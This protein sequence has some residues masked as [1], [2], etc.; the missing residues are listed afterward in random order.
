MAVTKLVQQSPLQ[1][2]AQI[3]VPNTF[4]I[5]TSGFGT[6]CLRERSLATYTCT[7]DSP[8]MMVAYVSLHAYLICCISFVNMLE[9]I[10]VFHSQQMFCSSW[11]HVSPISYTISTR[12]P[13]I[14]NVYVIVAINPLRDMGGGAPRTELKISENLKRR[15]TGNLNIEGPPPARET[16][17]MELGTRE[18]AFGLAQPKT[19]TRHC[20]RTLPRSRVSPYALTSRYALQRS[21]GLRAQ[22]RKLT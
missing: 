9:H 17:T 11:L 12:T 22:P 3:S 4:R 6:I 15:R 18:T 10:P 19:R 2:L 13:Y 1:C 7:A 5:A 14:Q 21:W 16:L 20:P 8:F